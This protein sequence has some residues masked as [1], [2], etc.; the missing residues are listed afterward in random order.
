MAKP[1]MF[2]IIVNQNTYDILSADTA[3]YSFM[4]ESRLYYSFDRLVYAADLPMLTARAEA[5][6]TGSFILRLVTVDGSAVPYY[7]TMEQ[8]EGAEQIQ[9]TLID[10][11][12]L[13]ASEK[14]MDSQ[15]R[16]QCKLLE[17][18]GDDFFLYDVQTN[19]I[20]LITKY[21]IAPETRVLSLQEFEMLLKKHVTKD[22]YGDVVEFIMALE[23]GNRYFEI[24]VDGNIIN[25]A[26]EAKYTHIKGASVYENGERM[27]SA[28]YIH[29]STERA[30]ESV[31]KLELDSL[32]GVLS[33][34]EITDLAIRTIDV[35]KQQNVSIA[36]LDVDHFKKVNDTYGH[37]M[38]DE[39][40][41]KVASIIKSEVGNSGVAGRI[42]G[43]EFL[44]LFYDAY[45]LE[46]SR[47]RLRS[48]KNTVITRFPEN[49]DNKPAIT[50]SIGCAAYPKDADNYSDLFALADFALY[51]AKEKGRNRYIIYDREKH[52]SIEE[53]HETANMATRINA[54]GD[55]SHGDIL[56]VMMDRIYSGEIYPLDK[57]LD[58]YIENFEMQ[59]ISIY[60]ADK[61]QV[62]HMVGE[63]VPAAEVIEET[64]AYIHGDFWKK[65]YMKGDVIINDVS[66]VEGKDKTVYELMKKQ[67][68]I[69]C[70][71]IQF[72]DKNGVRCIL[73]LEAV[74]K[75]LTWNS[76]HMRYYRLM[77]R[78]LSQ[79]EMDCGG[80]SR[81]E[82]QD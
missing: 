62:L 29:R 5:L 32:T 74:S 6:E 49:D 64:Q 47:E 51:R 75:K 30:A 45:D 11:V 26:Q 53:I 16:L 79:Y 12:S 78:I 3:F 28:G 80:E 21:N 17:L 22:R 33:K 27:M 81:T 46:A 13:I 52:G 70:I 66:I 20:K 82:Q 34:G 59:R 4:D 55:M 61:A 25:E 69:S 58:D 63:Q 50:L 67:G 2:K 8:G 40:L 77:A 35:E 23:T 73:S 44:I 18:Y 19:Q 37:M 42:G 57:L 43:D 1:R 14:E 65:R 71:H 39:V 72:Q 56:C 36:I 48:I 68:I 60:D 9:L 38:G 10:I 41:K 24:C 76:E 15:Y 54:R 31:K 7:V